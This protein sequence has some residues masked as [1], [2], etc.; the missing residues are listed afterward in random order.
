MYAQ[1]FGLKENPFALPPDPRYLYLSLR[2][3]EALAHLM[4]GI[5]GGGGFVQLTGEVGTGKTM[6][7]RALLE[8]LPDTVDIALVLYPFLSVREFM[9]AIL[10]DLRI[11]HQGEASLKTLIDTLNTYL[12]ENH[13][14]GRRTVLIVDEAHKLNREL[15]EQIRMLTNLETTK[16]KLLQIIL[17]GQPELAALLAQPDL[18]QLAQRITARYNLKALLP[19]ETCE[20]VAHR[21][22]VAGAQVPLFTAFAMQ[23]VY[24]LSGGVPRL[25]NIIC[26]RALLGA[27]GRGR[28]RVGMLTVT[29]AAAEVELSGMRRRFVRRAGWAALATVI[30][31]FSVWWFVPGFAGRTA[32]PEEP[33]AAAGIAAPKPDETAVMPTATSGG[34]MAAAETAVVTTAVAPQP[35]QLQRVLADPA[36][37]T[38]TDSAFAGLFTHWQLDY[39]QFAGITGCERAEKAKL[40]C[41]Y[42]SGT[43][44]NLRQLNRPV[45]V[46]L[47]DQS[48]GRH[49]VLLSHLTEEKATLEVSGRNY[50]FPLVEVDRF[51]FGKYLALW[52][53]PESGERVVRRGMRGRPVAW[54]RDALARYGLTRT[55][56]PASDLFDVELETQVREFQRRHQLEDDGVVGKMTLIYLSTYDTAV[57]QPLLLTAQQETVTR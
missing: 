38:D 54:V 19:R 41:L 11:A 7:I 15:L 48:G 49:H 14:K 45:I 47:V 52:S 31:A 30:V 2:H 4:Y 9:A 29:H 18:R 24:R 25:I 23:R 26:D 12:L 13:A 53:P 51:W 56:Q 46:E 16:E 3:Q 42:E 57:S 20:Y 44:N 5:T 40:R 43:W 36:A 6:M 34:A 50:E 32:S 55:T 37:A 27:Y 1:Y 35:P 8:R 10:D 39:T 33:P 17:V 21:L 22:R 28:N